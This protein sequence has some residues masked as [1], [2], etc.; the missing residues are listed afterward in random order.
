MGILMEGCTTIKQINTTITNNKITV[1]KTEFE[2]NKFIIL[3]NDQ[4]QTPIYLNKINE[5]NYA[6]L[7]MLCTH[8]NCDVKP[9]GSFLTCPCHGSE[10]DNDGKVLKGPATANLTAYQTQIKETTIIID[11]NQAIKS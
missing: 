8:K 1:N 7:L 6:A 10:F 3:N 2:G 4:L 9:T 5:Q 11:I